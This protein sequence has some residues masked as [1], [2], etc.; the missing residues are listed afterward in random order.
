MSIDGMPQ[1]GHEN[2]KSQ[3]HAEDEELKNQ[4]KSLAFGDLLFPSISVQVFKRSRAMAQERTPFT[5]KRL[6]NRVP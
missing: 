4:Q 3:K 6:K 1:Y 2:Y 5:P